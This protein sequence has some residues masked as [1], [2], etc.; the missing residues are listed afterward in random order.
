MMDEL[1]MAPP[2][3]AAAVRGLLPRRRLEPLLEEED[4]ESCTTTSVANEIEA[5]PSPD[6]VG[7]INLIA[8]IN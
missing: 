8:E 1:L 7:C 2:M 3:T 6:Q 5:T 4:S